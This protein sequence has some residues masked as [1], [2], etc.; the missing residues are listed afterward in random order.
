MWINCVY[1][2]DYLWIKFKRVQ[3]MVWAAVRAAGHFAGHIGPVDSC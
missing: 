3:L 2:V 1:H